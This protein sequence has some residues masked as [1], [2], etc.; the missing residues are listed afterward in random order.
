MNLSPHFTLSECTKSATAARLGI[1]NS[2]TAAEIDR[3]KA[4]CKA[5]LEPVRAHFGKPVMINSF[6]RCP[7]LNAEVGSKPSSQHI[8]G[9]AVDL[10]I[11]G[12][13]NLEVATWI[14]DNLTADQIIL[15]HYEPGK[16]DSGWVH[17][18]YK[19]KGCRQQ[20]LTVNSSGTVAGLTGAPEIHV[21]V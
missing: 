15:E 8:M 5:I 11:P 16:P 1:D 2:P 13:S 9:E 18:S 12:V 7:R 19:E 21:P 6:Y 3:M 10:E 4:V 20:C 17:V 14:R